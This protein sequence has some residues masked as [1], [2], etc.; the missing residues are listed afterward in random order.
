MAIDLKFKILLLEAGDDLTLLVAH[1]GQHV[2]H[3]DIFLD[4]GS[5]FLLFLFRQQ[6]K[7][8]RQQENEGQHGWN[9]LAEARDWNVRK[10]LTAVQL[11]A[12]LESRSGICRRDLNPRWTWKLQGRCSAGGELAAALS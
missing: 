2:H 5:R 6:R 7:A 3:V 12:S 1:C 10:I 9:E 8:G 4:R 11:H